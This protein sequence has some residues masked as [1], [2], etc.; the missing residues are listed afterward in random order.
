MAQLLAVAAVIA[1]TV[2]ALGGVTAKYPNAGVGCL[3]F[4]LCGANPDVPA[5]AVAVQWAHR[6]AAYAYAFYMIA[7]ATWSLQRRELESRPVLTAIRVAVG[8]VVLQVLIAGAMIGMKLPPVLRSAHEAT[9]VAIWLTTFVA[10]YLAH[11]AA[12][13]GETEPAAASSGPL[14][15][16][17][18]RA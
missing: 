17:T 9:G 1:I 15:T 18:V 14:S 3:A 2:V 11:R 16:A 4:P 10:A 7:L 13:V 5:S 12:A 8:L 6:L